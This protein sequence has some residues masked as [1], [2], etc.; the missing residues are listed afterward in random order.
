M[1]AFQGFRNADLQ[2]PLTA[3]DDQADLRADHLYDSEDIQGGGF[4]KTPSI[5]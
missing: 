1:I 5:L 3:F 4:W 2:P